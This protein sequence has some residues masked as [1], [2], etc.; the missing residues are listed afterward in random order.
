M[1]IECA[2]CF[3]AKDF[4]YSVSNIRSGILLRYR[5]NKANL[6]KKYSAS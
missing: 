2:M 5:T 1:I 4:C 3:I 6:N